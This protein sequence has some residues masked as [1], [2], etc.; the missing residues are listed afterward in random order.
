RTA[1]GE[2]PGA[3]A[4][5]SGNGGVAM[6]LARPQG[7]SSAAQTRPV[8]GTKTPA[9]GR[10]H[11]STVVSV[12]TLAVL[13][14]LVAGSPASAAIVIT[15]GPTYTPGGTWSC[16]APTAGSEKLAGGGTYTCT[17]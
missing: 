12:A 8:L 2:K 6:T 11:G 13:G 17:G 3:K 7:G 10:R 4:Q 16:T 5:V 14:L 9:R 1:R 15:S